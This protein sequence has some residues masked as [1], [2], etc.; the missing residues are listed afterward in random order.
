MPDILRI[1]KKEHPVVTLL[2]QHPL[3]KVVYYLMAKVAHGSIVVLY[4]DARRSEDYDLT[5]VVHVV[6]VTVKVAYGNCQTISGL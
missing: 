2:G 6:Y 5:K 1:L 4:F 3:A